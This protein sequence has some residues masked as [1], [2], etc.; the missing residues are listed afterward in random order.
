MSLEM[1]EQTKANGGV[2]SNGRWSNIPQYANGTL[3]AG[4]IFAAGEAGPE[5]V[6]H[7]GGRT[8]V[9]NKSQLASAMFSA[10]QAAMAPAAANF[11]SAAQSMGV[12][13]AGVDMETLAEM[14]R[15]GVEQ[16]MARSNDYD[17]QKVALLQQINEKDYNPEISTSSINRAQQRMNRRAGTTIV[18]VGT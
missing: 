12:A 15:Q 8:E 4:T 13:D 18:P 2:F 7:V 14:I 1:Y 3:N 6:G 17:R 5:I 9:L 16:A 10:V 11:A